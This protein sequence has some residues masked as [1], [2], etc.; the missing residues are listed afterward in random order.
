MKIAITGANGFIGQCVV[1]QAL[2]DGHQVLAIVR[3]STPD[4]WKQKENLSVCVCDLSY[5]QTLAK[6]LNGC[7]A[8]IHLAAQM[9]GNDVYQES[10]TV[11][12]NVLNSMNQ[13]GV[14]KLVGLSSIAVLDYMNSD[15]HCIIDEN[16]TLIS[17]T[18]ALGPYALMKRDQEILY[19]QWQ[20]D[21]KSLVILRPGIVYNAV[22][23]ATAHVG[24][25]KGSK[26][27]VSSHSGS[28]PVVH[29]DTVATAAVSAATSE[30]KNEA[31]N[32]VNDQLP[33]QQQYIEELKKRGN[34]AS[35][36]TLPWQLYCILIAA[37]RLPLSIV[38]KVPDAF[39]KNS[40][41]ARYTPF[42]FSNT[43]AKSLLNWNSYKAINDHA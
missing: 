21:D 29:V 18:K 25:T 12:K 27:I 22:N 5:Q 7:D 41:A 14:N 24:F 36:I 9:H 11:T 10:M 19:R 37:A 39:K 33:S 8:L 3:S 4:H 16:T 34:L 15:T 43:K 32:L 13:A 42:S 20:K 40:V 26:G 1:E 23:L 35:S 2:A 38:N 6:D 17:N 30:L 28:V 31:F